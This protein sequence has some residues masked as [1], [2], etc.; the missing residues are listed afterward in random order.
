MNTKILMLAVAGSALFAVATPS[1][2]ATHVQ[3]APMGSY[4]NPDG[5]YRFIT[6]EPSWQAQAAEQQAE[7]QQV[8]ANGGGGGSS[9]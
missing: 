6:P 1:L 4:Y 2:A 3:R 7:E 5:T 8:A 9:N